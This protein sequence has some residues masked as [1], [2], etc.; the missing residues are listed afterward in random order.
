MYKVII[1]DDEEPI[2]RGLTQLLPWESSGCQVVGTAADGRR[3]LELIRREKPDIL[4][5][6]IAMPG[7]DGL[8]LIA[9]LRSE[10]PELQI[11]ILSGYPQFSFAQRA[12]ELGVSGY[13]I[14][15][16][17]MSE[18]E[19][20]LQKMVGAL[21]QLE[22]AGQKAAAPAVT[23]A[24]DKTQAAGRG[25]A[26]PGP[27]P[28]DGPEARDEDP[29]ARASNFVLQQARAYMAEHYAER[30]T[31]PEVAAAVYVSQWHLSKLISRYTGQSFYDLLNQI[32]LKEACR[33]LADP[34]LSIA[35]VGERVGFADA[36]HFSKIFKKYQQ[37]SANAY[38]NQLRG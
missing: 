29:A 12:I 31:L 9:A 37:I 10:F 21:K 27:H 35:E 13:I 4:F 14:K 8:S 24:A 11:A 38:R 25:Q 3:A 15:P 36:A 20:V 30:L 1:V 7:M 2:V 18:L 34:S 26:P 28:D 32:R 17:R 19:A 5:T 16:S 22:A 6:D 23:G 33:L